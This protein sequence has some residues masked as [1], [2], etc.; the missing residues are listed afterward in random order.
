MREKLEDVKELRDLVRSLGR[1]LSVAVWM[2]AVLMLG[3]VPLGVGSGGIRGGAGGCEGA[4]GPGPQPG[5]L[6]GGWLPVVL[7]GRWVGRDKGGGVEEL[8]GTSCPA[9]AGGWLGG[10]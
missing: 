8:G 5:Q 7:V 3:Y 9:W 1:W 6:C 2:V 4:V 10:L